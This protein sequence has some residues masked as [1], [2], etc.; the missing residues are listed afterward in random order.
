MYNAHWNERL[1]FL[2]HMEYIRTVKK[3]LVTFYCTADAAFK[4][5]VKA[6]AA[7]R[8]VE[9]SDLVREA[10]DLFFAHDDRKNGRARETV[11]KPIR[12]TNV[13]E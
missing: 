1:H 3:S 12:Y 10:L 5:R 13:Q 11:V 4:R 2:S 8:G 9:M 6:E 7:V